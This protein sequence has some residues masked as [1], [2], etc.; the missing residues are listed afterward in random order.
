MLWL[1]E[2]NALMILED[3]MMAIKNSEETK[4]KHMSDMKRLRENKRN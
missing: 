1:R 2:I 4:D 3:A